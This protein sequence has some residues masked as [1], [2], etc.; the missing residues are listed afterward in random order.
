MK[1]IVGAQGRLGRAIC[2]ALPDSDTVAP[3]RHVYENW[4]QSDAVSDIEAF[5]EGLGSPPECI[6]VTAGL[7]DPT[8]TALAHARVNF[9]LPQNI[10]RA[11]SRQQIR[12]VTFGTMMEVL[13]DAR[14]ASPYLASKLSLATEV[15]SM[16]PHALHVRVNTLY[17]GNAHPA[18]HMFAGQM[19]EAIR[20]RSP[21]RMSP[22]VQLREYHHVDDEAEAIL[23]LGAS[24]NAGVIELHH[25][26][27]VTLAE[28]AYSTFSAFDA[29]DLL[30]IGA[31]PAPDNERADLE[32]V[33]NPALDGCSFRDVLTAM[34]AY[35]RQCLVASQSTR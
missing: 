27:P 4:W 7:I 22:G 28:L 2:A 16:H 11:A 14:T 9:H 17:G 31:L 12:V 35:M 26:A 1:L 19:L 6:F 8:A 5:L 10:L 32:Y 34:P 21:F 18:P 25:G 13:A 30:H 29:L 3:V 15:R 23:A 33:R 20:T 24:S